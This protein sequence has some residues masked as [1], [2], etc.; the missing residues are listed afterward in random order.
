MLL[1]IDIQKVINFTLSLSKT[2]IKSIFIL[3]LDC[4]RTFSDFRQILNI[5]IS[6]Q[7]LKV[8]LSYFKFQKYTSSATKNKSVINYEKFIV[9][10]Q[11]KARIKTV[12]FNV[13]TSQTQKQA[14]YKSL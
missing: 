5:H 11:N 4:I 14:H 6:F 13:L 12:R 10:L 7:I 9:F 1:F 8:Y 3:A 2:L